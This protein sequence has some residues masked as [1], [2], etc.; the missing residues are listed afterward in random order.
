MSGR[1]CSTC[2]TEVPEGASRC[3]GC[4]S[5]F[6]EANRCPHCHA[7]AAVRASK[8]GYVCMAC[9]KPRQV[10]PGTTIVDDP[11][12]LMPRAERRAAPAAVTAGAE[13]QAPARVIPPRPADAD[14]GAGFRA[15]GIFAIAGGVLAA[16]AA[17]VIIPGAGGILLAAALAGSGAGVG[18]LSLRAG[19][20]AREN[21]QSSLTANTEL[22]IMELAEQSGG[23]L[24][25][26]E[27][28][29]G[30]GL[31]SQEAED[32]LTSMTDGSRVSAELTGDG[33]VQYVFRE[34]R[35]KARAEAAESEGAPPVRA[36][37]DTSAAAADPELAEAYEEVEAMLQGKD[38]RE[39]SL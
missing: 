10:L 21:A 11:A 20:R 23:V 32:A 1:A 4:G 27:V 26:T 31:S 28:A 3:P 15:L 12:P 33:F 36:R 2:G 35:A 16:A 24:T 19:Q 25:V 34:L 8:A 17:A 5:V 18:T 30:L 9:N 13:G 37:V 22:A 29:R 39:G 38:E 6:G 7:I 14:A